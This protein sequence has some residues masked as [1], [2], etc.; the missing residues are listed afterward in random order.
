MNAASSVRGSKP[1]EPLPLADGDWNRMARIVNLPNAARPE[2][3]ELLGHGT[4]LAKLDASAPA[5]SATGTSIRKMRQ[6]AEMLRRDLCNSSDVFMAMIS[7]EGGQH[8]GF[9]VGWMPPTLSRH[10]LFGQHIAHLDSLISW[11]DEARRQLP[12]GRTG[13]KTKGSAG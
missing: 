5:P 13:N 10:R 3:E 4:F 7:P 2:L 9:V 1:W 11:L 12:K 8:H 6:K